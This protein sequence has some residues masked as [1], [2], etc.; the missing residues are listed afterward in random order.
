VTRRAEAVAEAERIATARG[1]T[2]DVPIRPHSEFVVL[3]PEAVRL[4]PAR[5]HGDGDPFM[6]TIYGITEAAGGKTDLAGLMVIGALASEL[7]DRGSRRRR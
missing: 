7:S 5:E 3:I 6:N 1:D 4:D 2:R